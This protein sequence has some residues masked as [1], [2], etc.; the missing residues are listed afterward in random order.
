MSEWKEVRLG[1]LGKT[2]TGLAGKSAADFGTGK[3]YIP[4][5]NIFTN[6]RIDPQWMEFVKVDPGERQSCVQEGDLF[7]TTSSETVE[8]VGMTSV[9]LDDIGEAYLNSFCF[10]FRLYDFET[11]LPEYA[12]HLFRGQEVRKAIS[13]LGQGSTRYNLPK[14]TLLE[15]LTLKLPDPTTQRTIARILGTVDGLIERT[16]A[17]I[18]KQQQIKQGLLHDLFTRGVD[19]HGALRPPHSEAPELYH[20]TELGWLPKGWRVERL[21]RL[22]SR[23]G[24]G[25]TPRGGS[26]IYLTEGIL[27]IRSQNVTNEGL[28]LDDVAYISEGMHEEMANSALASFDVLLNITGASIGR[29][30]YMP[31]GLGPANTNQHVC[32]V[33][34]HDPCLSDAIYL[35]EYLASPMG[36]GLVYRSIAGGNREG[37]NYQQIKGFLIPWPTEGERE[38]IAK[39]I[40]TI[41]QDQQLERNTLHKYRLLKAGLMQDLLTGR[42][43]VESIMEVQE[44]LA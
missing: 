9:L 36:Q 31:A 38:A 19:E 35:S 27:F 42:V 43:S 37:L 4:Y 28:L 8:E 20:E 18:A 12:V 25:V 44:P 22:T 6:G 5:L 39:R 41:N 32:C 23:V 17:L 13:L 15:R 16:E 24:S 21:G 11:L 14:T 26:E 30:C 1:A 7:F 40:S 34:T 3:P 33:R 2:F 10:G 29:C